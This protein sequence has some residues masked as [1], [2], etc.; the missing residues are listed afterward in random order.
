MALPKIHIIRQGECLVS[1]S[2]KYGFNPETI[3]NDPANVQL[4]QSRQNYHV[5]YPGDRVFIPELR[6]KEEEAVTNN[7]HKF[8]R[9]GVPVYLHLQL[10]NE[11]REP[12]ANKPFTLRV[13]GRISQDITDG[14]GCLKVPIPPPEKEGILLIDNHEFNIRIG[15]LNPLE[16]LSGVRSRL[17]NLGYKAGAGGEEMDAELRS[18]LEDF[19]EDQGLPKTGEID[20]TTINALRDR[21][22][23]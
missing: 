3:W 1:I 15:Y 17:S 18:A 6:T 20:E 23:F 22:K 19:Q 21:H 7:R 16:Y 12:L 5:L 2:L 10:F 9:K 13:S 11:N 8:R 14:E 4:K